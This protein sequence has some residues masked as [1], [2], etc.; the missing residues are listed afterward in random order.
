[1]DGPDRIRAAIAVAEAGVLSAQLD[2]LSDAEEVLRETLDQVSDPDARQILEGWPGD[3]RRH[4]WSPVNRCRRSA[5]EWEPTAA[6]AASLENAAAGR[7]ELAGRIATKASPRRRMARPSSRTS[8]SICAWRRRGRCCSA[9][10]SM[11]PKCMQRAAYEAALDERA[12]FPRA[13]WCMARGFILVARGLPRSASR[14]LREAAR[15]FE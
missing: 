11:M 2:R 8:T 14:A 1:M 7:F 9:V 13:S 3:D 10:E 4:G 15:E 5:R 12:D 6:L